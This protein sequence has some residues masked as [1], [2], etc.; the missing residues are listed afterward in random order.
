MD[1]LIH[2]SGYFAL[3][4]HAAIFIGLCLRVLMQRH[5]PG[6]SLA[7]MLLALALPYVGA[8]LYLLIGERPL[9][10]RRGKRARELLP[11]LD[12]WVRRLPRQSDAADASAHRWRPI[13]RTSMAATG[14]PSQIGNRLA[15][16]S[17]SGAILRQI[18]DDIQA[19]THTVLMEF[20]IWY[21]GGAADV[22][23]EALIAA[24]QRG[25]SCCVLLD[26]TGSREFFKSR[27]PARMR[28][29]GVRLVSALPVGLLRAAFVRFDLR[30]HRK[31]V[32]VDGRIAWTG[33]LNLV[34]PRFFKQHAGVGEWVDAMSRIEGPVVATLAGVFLWDWCVET[35]MRPESI[36]PGLLAAM[37]PPLT[38]AGEI[39]VLPSGP[40]FEGDGAHRLLLAA[41][42][43]A[44]QEI[45]LTTPYFVP[46]E[47]L[48]L[49]IEAAALR[50]VKVVV[51]LPERVDSMLVRYA[52]RSLFDR[53]L[54]AGV[55]IEQFSGGLLHTK[56][57]V[58]DRSLALFGTT[59]L[60]IRSLRLN[61]ELTLVVYDI[62]FAEQLHALQEQYRLSAQP[63]DA[64]RWSR[65]GRATRLAENLARLVSPL[66]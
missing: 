17:D 25:V 62:A 37:S 36:A 66:L 28:T 18:G 64:A 56:S 12:D 61:F 23:A 2:L 14:L 8:G 21:P 16:A 65:R 43:V 22:V 31:L 40:G 60:D 24:A 39:Q 10:R 51:V 49:A 42:Y 30:L 9:G 50:G 26:A 45:V 59:N 15:L 54:A 41:F 7:W 29:A 52:S 13:Q 63:L 32:I 47:P 44:Q 5:P 48:A 27:W 6:T 19:A 20:Y 38:D 4:A 34:D 1:T 57:V 58:V 3:I 46:D 11:L 35:G 55:C 33:S 53:L